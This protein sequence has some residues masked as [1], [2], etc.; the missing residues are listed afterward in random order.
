M[1][2]TAPASAGVK[3]SK[4]LG[5]KNV[6][7]SIP[8]YKQNLKASFNAEL[9]SYVNG[10]NGGYIAPVITSYS[11]HYTKLYDINFLHL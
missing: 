2:E 4:G 6:L 8:V 3:K 11:I 9:N 7:E 1:H 5:L 10:L